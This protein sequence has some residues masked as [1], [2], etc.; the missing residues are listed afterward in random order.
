MK[1][2]Q[3][4]LSAAMAAAL[5]LSGAAVVAQ[6]TG[7][8]G[9]S[10]QGGSGQGS[11]GMGST[12]QGSTGS[13]GMNSS[14]ATNGSA[15]GQAGSQSGNQRQ[16]ASADASFMKNA[17]QNG[18]AEVKGSQVALQKAKDPKVRE[19]AQ[20]MI[21]DHTQANQE[22]MAIATAKNV[23]LPDG[24]SMMQEGKLKLLSAADGDDFD[25]R[26]VESMGLQAH[27]DTIALF[28]KAS[29]NA[30]DP[31]VKAFATKTLPKLEH[32]LSMAQQLPGA[33]DNTKA[34]KK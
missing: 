3:F 27:R 16:L 10:G 12:G 17:A 13:A 26:Y 18:H 28:Q 15:S 2:K 11:S 5:A 32:H 19:F 33:N 21:D 29:R 20:Q 24:P 4:F 31:E 1:N 7:G 34:S 22:L 25:R 23:K 9:G 6:G 8:Q 14:G 30:K